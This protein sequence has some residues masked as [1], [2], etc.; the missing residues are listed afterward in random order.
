MA[1]TKKATGKKATAKKANAKKATAKKATAKKA[2]AKKAT[3]KKATAERQPS[4]RRVSA[5]V[6]GKSSVKT[7]SWPGHVPVAKGSDEE[8]D[9]LATI[10]EAY[11]SKLNPAQLRALMERGGRR[12]NP[13]KG[14][15]PSDLPALLKIFVEE[16]DGETEIRPFDNCTSGGERFFELKVSGSGDPCLCSASGHVVVLDHEARVLATQWKSH[17]VPIAA[18]LSA[19]LFTNEIVARGLAHHSDAADHA[20]WLCPIAPVLWEGELDFSGL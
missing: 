8:D 16:F 1:T 5:S 3:A 7:A 10:M 20:V 18:V 12:R 13:L 6:R 19:E 11:A 15:W 2:T 14:P 4:S 9:L 17:A